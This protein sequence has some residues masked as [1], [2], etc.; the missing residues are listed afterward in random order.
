MQTAA[1][2]KLNDIEEAIE[3]FAR[4]Y[5]RL[6]ELQT[7]EMKKSSHERLLPQKGD[8]KTG[9][10]GE[11]WAIRYA[12]MV[13]SDSRVEFGGHSQEGWDFKVI[14]TRHKPLY[15]QL[16][17]ASDFGTGKL[18][19]ICKPSRRP[20]VEDGDELPRYWDEL[21]LLWLD[22]RLRPVVLWRFNPDQVEFNGAACLR[23]KSLR[24]PISRTGGSNCFDWDN[25]EMVTGFI[26]AK[27]CR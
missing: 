7:R 19:P 24:R 9:L 15:I 6:E 10:I 20:S 12:R 1:I 2:N 11:Y 25:A 18:S 26:E 23:G 14:R 8:Q 16:K 22:K 27:G 4:A 3:D 17:T 13:F 21:W 5:Q